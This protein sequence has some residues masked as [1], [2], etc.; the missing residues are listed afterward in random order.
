MVASGGGVLYALPPL[1]KKGSLGMNMNDVAGLL[2]ITIY[3]RDKLLADKVVRTLVADRITPCMAEQGDGSFIVVTRVSLEKEQTKQGYSGFQ[4]NVVLEIASGSY[5]E[6]ITIAKE[7]FRVLMAIYNENF[8][9]P[10]KAGVFLPEFI[11]STEGFGEGKY[12]QRLEYSFK[13]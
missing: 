10:Q 9:L 1:L 3:L 6:S 2:D 12:V 8:N 11:G 7:V 5:R 13:V 4:G